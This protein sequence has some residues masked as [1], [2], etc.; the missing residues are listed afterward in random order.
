MFAFIAIFI[1]SIIGVKIIDYIE[2]G[3]D[4]KKS[5]YFYSILLVFSAALNNLI[6][7]ILFHMKSQVLNYLNDLPIYFC[8]FTTI[9]IVLNII[10]AFAII[11]INKNI[12]FKVELEEDSEKVSKKNKRNHKKNISK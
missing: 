7:N 10:L 9:S 4:L 11:V 6:A 8:K 5:V 3:I 2:K 12:S 1:P